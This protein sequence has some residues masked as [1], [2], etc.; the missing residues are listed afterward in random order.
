VSR[1]S[2]SAHGG[3]IVII[4]YPIENIVF[5]QV[6]TEVA[7][8]GVAN[9]F[10]EVEARKYYHYYQWVCFMLFFQVRLISHLPFYQL[11]AARAS[12]MSRARRM[13]DTGFIR[14]PLSLSVCLHFR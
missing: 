10:G 7:H 3:V 8:P 4:V 6:G 11:S 2:A 5:P 1:A 14:S 12:R 13:R 9:D